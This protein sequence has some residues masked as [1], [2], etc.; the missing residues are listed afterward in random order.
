MYLVLMDSI[1]GS[2]NCISKVCK[3]SFEVVCEQGFSKIIKSQFGED[4]KLVSKCMDHQNTPEPK[5][6]F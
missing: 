3:A 2:L 5:I 4:P 1:H 6:K